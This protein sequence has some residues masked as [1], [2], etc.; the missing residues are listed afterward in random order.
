MRVLFLPQQ[1]QDGW[2]CSRI[3]YFL[4]DG[5]VLVVRYNL[6]EGDDRLMLADGVAAGELGEDCGQLVLVV[7]ETGGS[8]WGMQ[9]CSMASR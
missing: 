1:R 7:V 2:K 8:K 6:A 3:E 9:Y 5:V 4:D